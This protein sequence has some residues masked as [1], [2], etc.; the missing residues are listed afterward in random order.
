[1]RRYARPLALIAILVV[2]AAVILG[3]QKIQIGDFQRGSDTLF[4]LSLGLDLQGGSHL[5]YRA[6]DTETRLPINPA[7]DEMEALKRSIERRVNASGLGE[8]IIQVLGDDRLLIQLPGVR[9]PDRAKSII[10]ET[11]QLVY[12]HRSLNVPRDLDDLEVVSVSAG[13]LTLE[14]ELSDDRSTTPEA[15]VTA[16]SADPSTAA[17]TESGELTAEGEVQEEPRK[18]LWA[19]LC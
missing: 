9:D 1:M 14:G 16:E 11:A 6:V 12:K 15:E 5:V 3:I 13:M 7:P 8:P 4:G 17:S 2:L 10:G 19:L 18:S